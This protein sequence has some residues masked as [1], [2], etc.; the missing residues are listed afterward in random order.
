MSF[1]ETNK[2]TDDC[3]IECYMYTVSDRGMHLAVVGNREEE[4]NPD[5]EVRKSFPEDVTPV[6]SLR[7]LAFLGREQYKERH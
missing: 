2:Q 4:P 3:S 5:W 1:D 7:G 6:L